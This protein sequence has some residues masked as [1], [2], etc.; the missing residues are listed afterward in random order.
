MY[1]TPVTNE[2]RLVGGLEELC[3]L[4]DKPLERDVREFLEEIIRRSKKV[5][6][7]KYRTDPDLPESIMI[8]QLSW[9]F[10]IG[11]IDKEEF[12]DLKANYYSYKQ[13]RNDKLI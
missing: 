7:R 9:L 13:T 2:L 4:S 11:V 5:L 1:F 8:S 12:N 3:F 6:L 10:E